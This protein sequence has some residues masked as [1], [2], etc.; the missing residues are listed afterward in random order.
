MTRRR[1]LALIL[2][3]LAAA[4]AVAALGADRRGRRAAGGERSAVVVVAMRDLAGV[5]RFRPEEVTLRRGDVLRFVLDGGVPHNVEFPRDRVPAGADLRGLWIGP[6]LM[7]R[8]EVYD[9]RI[10]ERF[11]DGVYAFR[12]SPHSPLGMEGRLVVRGAA[13]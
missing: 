2:P 5:Y 9:V 7:T 6:Y 10:D 1:V 4:S 13:A 8:G 12:C 11:P 3:G